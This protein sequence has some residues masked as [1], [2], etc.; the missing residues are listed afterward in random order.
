MTTKIIEVTDEEIIKGHEFER[1]SKVADDLKQEKEKKQKR[2]ALS[3]VPSVRRFVGLVEYYLYDHRKDA[4]VVDIDI[5][6]EK[7]VARI[8]CLNVKLVLRPSDAVKRELLRTTAAVFAKNDS[9]L[10][11]FRFVLEYMKGWV[12]VHVSK[13]SPSAKRLHWNTYVIEFS[14]YK[15]LADKSED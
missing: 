3:S 1:L 14:V 8:Q 4:D 2:A 12:K 6:S 5:V 7:V 9:S 13:Q 11:S 15:D 10:E